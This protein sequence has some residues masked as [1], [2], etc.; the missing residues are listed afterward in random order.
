MSSGRSAGDSI[1]LGYDR[2]PGAQ[3]ALDIAIDLATGFDLPLVIVH[4]VAPPGHVGEEA[5]EA[6][7]AIDELDRTFIAPAVAAAEAAGAR[8]VVE[9]LDDKP[10]QALVTAA[11]RHDAR[12]I[13][14]GTWNESPLRGLI[15]G[16]VAHRLLQ[17]SDR[18]VLC[19]PAASD[20]AG[21]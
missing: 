14:V 8:V 17:L 15:L 3:R 18:P 1:V 7:E 11:D 5:S 4:G 16:S 2:A 12:V 9:V 19:V 13:V 21:E 10:A 6:R 20:D